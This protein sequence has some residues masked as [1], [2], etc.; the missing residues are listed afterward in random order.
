MVKVGYNIS[1]NIDD[2]KAMNEKFKNAFHALEELC[3]NGASKL[4]I[5]ED[6]LYVSWSWWLIQSVHR[7]YYGENRT[8]VSEFI[9][10]MFYDYFIFYDMIISC[11]KHEPNTKNCIEAEKLKEE[12]LVLIERWN[13]GLTLL[14]G[15]YKNDLVVLSIYDNVCSKLFELH[16]NV[17]ANTSSPSQ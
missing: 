9:K 8:K 7:Y 16:P 13:K 14:K 10:K 11:I 15:L 2:M 1:Y 6:K 12:N 4:G 3:E 5:H 17:N